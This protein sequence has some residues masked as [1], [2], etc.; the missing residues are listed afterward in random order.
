MPVRL[1]ETA[2]NAAIRQAPEIGRKDLSD[3]Q[4]PG[5][6]LRVAA[7]G[8]AGWVLACRDQHGRMRRFPVGAWPHM[9][10]KDAREA[11]RAL[12]VEVRKGIDPIADRRQTRA[13]GRDAK[14]GVGT[15]SALLDLYAAKIGKGLKSWPPSR[16]RVEV[17]FAGQLRKPL[18]TLTR[19]ELQ[20]AIDGYQ[21]QQ[22]A[23]GAAHCLRPVLKWAAPRGHVP[24][25][26]I[27]LL[28][29]SKPRRR[30]RVLEVSELKALLPV[31]KASSRPYAAA[32]RL[33]LLTLLRREEVCGARWRD[34]NWDART[35]RVESGR[36]KN[37]VEHRVPL[38]RQAIELL[39]Q[40]GPGSPADLIVATKTGGRLT[41][42]DRD[43]K[44]V[45]MASDTSGWTR[46]DL[47]RT[48]ATMLGESG[49]LP[50]VIEAALN[51]VTVHSQVATVYN[52]SRYRPQVAEALQR[53]ADAFDGLEAAGVK[54]DRAAQA[55]S[56]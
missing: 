30:E 34:I 14:E 4:L 38:S 13:L 22:Q 28:A 31:L 48:G 6:R 16:R 46:H 12:R 26:L 42:W 56:E 9:G 15:L 51:H 33:M 1:T 49:E 11:A 36:A 53:L 20:H 25:D 18:L 27:D 23:R 29:P 2:I 41:N 37:K 43:T 5:L 55:A 24:P 40:L 50:H 54:G 8:R 47:R 19:R 10:I 21:S 32:M 17:V 3:S 44:L 52:Q 39:R 45:M 7:T 35:W